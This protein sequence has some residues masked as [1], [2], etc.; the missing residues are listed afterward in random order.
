MNAQSASFR[1]FVA[2]GSAV[3]LKLVLHL[4]YSLHTYLA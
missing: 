3:N 4:V 1:S 2:S